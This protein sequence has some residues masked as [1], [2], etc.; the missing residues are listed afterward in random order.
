MTACTSCSLAIGFITIII[1]SVLSGAWK[2]YE[3][4]RF[5]FHP[6]GGFFGARLFEGLAGCAGE[7]RRERAGRL[8]KSPG[9]GVAAVHV[10]RAATD[11]HRGRVVPDGRRESKRLN[12]RHLSVGVECQAMQDFRP[13]DPGPP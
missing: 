11:A 2:L 3:S 7:Q 1:S 9:V 4:G 10:D 12:D 13:T 6:T 5:G 8:A